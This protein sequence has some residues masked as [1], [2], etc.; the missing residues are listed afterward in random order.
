MEADEFTDDFVDDMCRYMYLIELM[1]KFPEI[2]QSFSE[3]KDQYD[4]LCMAVA[5]IFSR[6]TQEQCDIVLEQHQR[7]LLD[8]ANDE[9]VQAGIESAKDDEDEEQE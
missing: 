6:L 1:K 8:M 9:T 2:T 5:E 3:I 4:G 7:I